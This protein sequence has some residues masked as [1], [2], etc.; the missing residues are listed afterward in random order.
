MDRVSSLCYIE[1]IKGWEIRSKARLCLESI[2][3]AEKV[4]F[5]I[6]LLFVCPSLSVCVGVWWGDFLF[7]SLI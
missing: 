5:F 6:L 7:F 3:L 1:G 4:G 2:R